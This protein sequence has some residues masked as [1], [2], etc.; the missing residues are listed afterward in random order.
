MGKYRNAKKV[1]VAEDAFLYDEASK[2]G[3]ELLTY[4]EYFGAVSGV[5]SLHQ[6]LLP[7]VLTFKEVLMSINEAE[8]DAGTGTT[9]TLTT[10]PDSAT[11]FRLRKQQRTEGSGDGQSPLPKGP[12]RKL[13]KAKIKSSPNLTPEKEKNVSWQQHEN[14]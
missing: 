6:R 14:K 5:R 13:S 4:A 3:E 1:E 2:Q 8:E 7:R 12:S 9:T 10:E 11:M